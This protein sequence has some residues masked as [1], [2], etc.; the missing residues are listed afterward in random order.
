M[1]R[2]TV[3]AALLFAPF[4]WVFAQSG[5][6]VRVTE[7]D[8]AINSI[9]LHR[10]HD[11]AVQVIDSTGEPVNGATVTFL[12]PANGPSGTFGENGL[13][14]T[15]QTD[16]RGMAAAHGLRPNAIPGQFHIRVTANW[17][18]ETAVATLAQTNAEPVATAH[19]SKTILILA[20]IGG[21]AAGGAIAAT[22]G[23]GSPGAAQTASTNSSGSI[24]AGAP[25]IGP[26]H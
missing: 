3:L 22:H 25:S 17:R 1:S 18:G 10:G 5:L 6:T 4:T 16:E 26:P 24:T 20:L 23:G 11:P 7:G 9:R 8:G 14:I 21:A 19:H 13:S 12:L 2:H 15:L